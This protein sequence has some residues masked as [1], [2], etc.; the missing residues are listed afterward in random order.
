MG[1]K[2]KRFP[3]SWEVAVNKITK[4]E[5]LDK[6][7]GAGADGTRLECASLFEHMVCYFAERVPA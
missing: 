6:Y 5:S 7:D 4:L 1:N 2:D 3:D